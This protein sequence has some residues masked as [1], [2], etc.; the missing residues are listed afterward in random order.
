MKHKVATITISLET[1]GGMYRTAAD[2]AAYTEAM[3]RRFPDE[4]TRQYI[5]RSAFKYCDAKVISVQLH[6]D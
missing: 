1:D 5:D 6:D 4:Q 3:M 2:A